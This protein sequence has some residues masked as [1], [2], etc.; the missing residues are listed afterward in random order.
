MDGWIAVSRHI[1]WSQGGSG[2]RQTPHLHQPAE[3]PLSLADSRRALSLGSLCFRAVKQT[4]M[5]GLP[6]SPEYKGW[7]AG[8][9]PSP[10]ALLRLLYIAGGHDTTLAL[11]PIAPVFHFHPS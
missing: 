5:G 3:H 4:G 10:P 6:R 7:R 9:L 1:I 2:R 11:F 8:I